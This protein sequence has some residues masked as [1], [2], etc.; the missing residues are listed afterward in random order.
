M[1]GRIC[2]LRTL[3]ES[4]HTI[5]DW[6]NFTRDVCLDIIQKNN[7]QV[8]EER[9]EAETNESEFQGK[10]PQKKNVYGVW[11]FEAS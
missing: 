8:G 2:D 6:Y 10:V 1:S 9:K 5:V 3:Y 7:E 4:E 11:V